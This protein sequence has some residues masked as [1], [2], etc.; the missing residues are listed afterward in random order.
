MSPARVSSLA[1]LAAPPVPLGE[2]LPKPSLCLQQHAWIATTCDSPPCS[3]HTGSVG[4]SGHLAL[5]T[6]SSS[7]GLGPWPLR[8]LP[9]DPLE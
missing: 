6:L 4:I 3:H 5:L 9:Q 1:L 2:E 8:A 7:A